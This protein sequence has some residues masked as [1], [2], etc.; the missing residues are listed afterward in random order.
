MGEK[1]ELR[2]VVRVEKVAFGEELQEQTHESEERR[3]AEL[4]EEQGGNPTFPNQSRLTFFS[5]Q[6]PSLST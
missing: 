1:E 6:P 4:S 5:R 2:E 3:R